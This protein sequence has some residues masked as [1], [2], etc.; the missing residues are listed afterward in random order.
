MRPTR[1]QLAL[2]LAKLH[3]GLT[4]RSAEWTS[5]DQKALDYSLKV[6]EYTVMDEIRELL[7]GFNE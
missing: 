3:A 6:M 4:P 7:R 5:A 2:T 1:R